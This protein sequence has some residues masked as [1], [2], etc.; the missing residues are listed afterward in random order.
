MNPFIHIETLT[1]LQ[2]FCKFR[3][4]EGREGWGWGVWY[5]L[6]VALQYQSR[7]WALFSGWLYIV[8]RYQSKICILLLYIYIYIDYILC[9]VVSKGFPNNILTLI[10]RL[11]CDDA[12]YSILH[13]RFHIFFSFFFLFFSFSHLRNNCPRSIKFET[14][15]RTLIRNGYKEVSRLLFIDQEITKQIDIPEISR[16]SSLLCKYLNERISLTYV[17]VYAY[18]Y[19]CETFPL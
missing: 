17:C 18:E 19:V 13:T 3:W 9:I 15:W 5:W 12:N 14:V 16:L 4:A 8:L 6:L 11:L 1:D 2:A 7:Q 10:I